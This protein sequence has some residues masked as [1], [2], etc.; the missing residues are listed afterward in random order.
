MPRLFRAVPG[1]TSLALV[2]FLALP[3]PARAASIFVSAPASSTISEPAGSTTFTITLS[4]SPTSPVSI[5]LDTSDATE[6]TP[7]PVQAVLDGTNWD[8][9]VMVT[10]QAVDDALQDGTQSC[11]VLTAPA[12]SGDDN[13]FEI[14]PDDVTVS[15]LDDE[16]P[17]PD[18]DGDGIPDGVDNC[19]SVA[20]PSQSD[21]DG[22]GLG[23]ACDP[24]DDGDGVSDA[25][26]NAAPNGGDG[27]GDGT[28]DAVQP[29]VASLPAAAGGGYLT[30]QVSSLCS[31]IRS[32]ST[33]T[34]SA[35]PPDLLFAYPLGLVAFQIPCSS[36][37]VELFFHGLAEVPAGWEYRQ[38]GPTTPGDGTTAAWYTLPGVTFGTAP[39]GAA[40]VATASF[41]LIDGGLGDDTAV[42][43][44]IAGQG[45]LA[46]PA[47]PVETPVLSFPGLAALAAALLAAALF[48]LGRT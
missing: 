36:P 48:R 6:C 33:L 12:I 7:S 16:P 27:N 31:Q 2:S 41:L 9:G 10:I 43:G 40:T 42:D 26:E 45:G 13:F 18:G 20:N 17:L 32:V 5:D 3:S 28:A 34:E 29:S 14:D 8:T 19:P 15:V 1:L 22:D 37:T 30:L 24:D 21:L 23:D 38:Y 47:L 25:V 46:Q 11:T 39:V 44:L 4:Q 35:L